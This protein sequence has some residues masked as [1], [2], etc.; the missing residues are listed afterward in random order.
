MLDHRYNLNMDA[1][2]VAETLAP[3]K[4]R[5]YSLGLQR[6][7][8]VGSTAKGVAREDSDVDLV[9]E[10]Q[11][12]ATFLAFMEVKELIESALGVPIDLTTKKALRPEIAEEVLAE[13]RQVA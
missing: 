9:A 6:L 13:A 4:G 10:F 12:K 1:R 8:L 2:T 11:G 7:L 3:L 5:L